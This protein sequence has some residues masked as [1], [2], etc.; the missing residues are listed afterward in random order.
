M[1]A[2]AGATAM[3]VSLVVLPATDAMATSNAVAP[4]A[5]GVPAR[6]TPQ[7]SV[8][9]LDAPGIAR[10]VTYNPDSGTRRHFSRITVQ[11]PPH[12]RITRLEPNCDGWT[13]P[14]S[15]AADGKSAT[16][17]LPSNNWIWIYP[18]LV[19][20]IAD[21]DAPLTGGTYSGTFSLDGDTQ[22]LTVNISPGTQGAISAFM[23]NAPNNGGA[24]VAFVLP[25]SNAAQSGLQ[26]GDVITAVAG[27]S[28]PTVSDVNDAIDGR[29]AGMR[30]PVT[31]NRGGQTI[32]L[33]LRLD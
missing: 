15:I 16:A 24:S 11:A 5:A 22:P 12:T 29:R 14:V 31:I 32:N 33:Q 20:V 18:F 9:T 13:C 6:V 3:L 30:V 10:T 19:D 1:L 21:D 17:D 7:Q 28:T 27:Q 26:V 4:A 8:P 2:S 23:T 25:G